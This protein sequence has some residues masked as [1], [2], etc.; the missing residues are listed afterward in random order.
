MKNSKVTIANIAEALDISPISVS[1][2]L[3]GQTGVSEEL[4]TRIID[5]AKEMGYNKLKSNE[6]LNIL[7]LHQ[8]PYIQ[9][10]SN[11]SY[12]VQGVEKAIQSTG[13]EYSVEFVDKENQEKLY[14][15]YKLSKGH[16][17]DGV[18]FIGEFE[19]KYVEF[20]RQKIR[21]VV[22]YTGYAPCYDYD[23]V[24]FNFSNGGYLQCEY[25]IKRGHK[26]IGFIG[27]IKSFKSKEKLM[28]ITTALEDYR[29]PIN[30]DFFMDVEENSNGKI[31]EM[32]SCEEKPTAIICQWDFIAIKLI[33][34]LYE[35]GIKVPEDISVIGSG[36]S[37]MSTLSIPA[38][39]TMDLNIEY[40][41]ETAVSLL[42]KRIN[43]PSKPYENITINSSLIERDSVKDIF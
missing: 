26:K 5:K 17:F 38:L 25:L 12:K 37:E 43:N 13:A 29:V 15:P 21:N 36:N 33:K 20:I 10:N 4:R 1:R 2:A 3:S 11:F 35:R 22:I 34:L 23:S 19:N 6:S 7:V 27:N 16:S 28:G 14:L 18:I 39:T 31:L 9:D 42:L 41:C 24:W 32:L 8:K 30:E 40:S